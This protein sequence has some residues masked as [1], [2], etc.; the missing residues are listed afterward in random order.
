LVLPRAPGPSGGAPPPADLPFRESDEHEPAW[1]EHALPTTD[2]ATDPTGQATDPTVDAI[3]LPAS[4]VPAPLFSGA[5][6]PGAAAG[7]GPVDAGTLTGDGEDAGA[8]FA[9]TVASGGDGRAGTPGGVADAR[10]PAPRYPRESRLRGEEGVVLEVDLATDGSVTAVRVRD[11]AGYPR[12]AAAAVNKGRSSPRPATAG[13]SRRWSESRSG[14][15]SNRH[16]SP[17]RPR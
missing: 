17:R 13:R 8:A 5:R 4:E 9:A 16:D 12:L 6:P 2:D 1:P 3:G 15:T 10:L 14:S 7:T 11:D